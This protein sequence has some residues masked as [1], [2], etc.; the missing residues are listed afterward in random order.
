MHL[1]PEGMFIIQAVTLIGLPFFIWKF[2]MVNKF[3]PLVVI[4]ITM[5][6]I[7]GPSILGKFFPAAFDTIFAAKT[8]PALNG[9]AWLALIL[10]GFLTGLHL[11][12]EGMAKKGMRF[13]G[14]SISSLLI[15]AA[16]GALAAF[17]LNSPIFIGEKATPTSFI[18]GI[19]IAVAVT[20]LPVLGSILLEVGLMNKDLGKRVLGYATLT[21][22]LL[23]I[24][25][26]ILIAITNASGDGGG[27]LSKI[28]TTIL[29][30]IV[31]A[32]AMY[33]VVKPALEWMT[34]K[35]ILSEKINHA[36]LVLIFC[37]ILLSALAT[38]LIGIHY[39]LGALALGAMMPRKIAHTL[40]HE[41][42]KFVGVALL[43][44]FFM[45]TGLKTSF[46]VE[47]KNVWIF[48]AVMMVVTTLGKVI[49]TAVPERLSG[50]TWHQAIQAG[51]LMRTKG[52]M[53]VVV[54][55]IMFAG[56]II[57]SITFS[58]M[59]L[60]AIFTT[61]LTKP[62]LILVDYLFRHKEETEDSI[63]S[64]ELDNLSVVNAE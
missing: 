53:D 50:A 9:L 18:L 34:R 19:S 45:L 52:L 28:L 33:K 5:G 10:F 56:G 3:I 47:N 54:L 22:G 62:S 64:V 26:S 43:P 13:I 63:S 59:L 2:K 41:M 42:D 1:P 29:L 6:I 24:F 44:F 36:Q 35:N 57:S 46:D 38:E 39:L 31:F 23:W 17:F 11:D 7:L 8:L 48:F 16:M 30:S 25:V 15:P 60:T 40:N 58:A 51:M 61:A 55:N 21:D 20:A 4:Q 27:G 49:G 32:V 12:T 14:T 37:L